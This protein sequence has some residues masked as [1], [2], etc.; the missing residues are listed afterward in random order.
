VEPVRPKHLPNKPGVY[1]MRDV[2]GQIVYVG[3]ANDL[4]KRVS[5]YFDPKRTDAKTSNMMP[6]VRSIDYLPCAGEREALL[7]EQRLIRKLQPVFN[8]MWRDDKSYP[9][10]RLTKEDY[11]RLFLTRRKVED[12]SEY[13]GPFPK[14]YQVKGLLRWL[15]R[16]RLVPLRPCNYDFTE[17]K[18]LD[19]KKIQA[20][21]YYH[22]KECPAPCAGPAAGR[23]GGKEYRRIARRASLFFRGRFDSLRKQLEKDMVRASKELEYERAKDLR[24]NIVALEHVGQRVSLHE[25]T[26]QELERRLGASRG[27]SELQAA[28]GLAKPPVHV[29]CFDISHLFGR[30]TV[31]S[32]VCF[33]DGMPNKT[34]YRHFKIRTVEGIDD[35][36]SM[37]ET[38]F[39]RYS[40]FKEEDG[41]MPDLIVVDGGKGQLSMAAEALA[42]AKVQVPLASLAKREEEVFVPGKSEPLVLPRE[43]PALH[44]LQRLRDEAHRFGITF[45]RRWRNKELLGEDK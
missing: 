44:L 19:K 5:Q 27:V 4:A 14:V 17:K 12:G 31:G 28:L 1:L 22:T 33:V 38:V 32:M 26:E 39:R 41:S 6:L 21:L 34:H 30:Q 40:G 24:D 2:S 3:K 7:L 35:F 25:V 29:E 36:K 15:W 20:C 13:F 23:I 42:E 37:K 18:P 9:F 8:T 45:H 11:P 43:S 16:S 10:V